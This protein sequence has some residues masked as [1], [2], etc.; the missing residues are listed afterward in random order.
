MTFDTY[1]KRT[2][3]F[4]LCLIIFLTPV[5][6][7]LLINFFGKDITAETNRY[8]GPACILGLAIF[9]YLRNSF[10]KMYIKDGELSFLEQ[11][12]NTS[13]G[14]LH[15]REISKLFVLANDYRRNQKGTSDGSG[16][17]VEVHLQSGKTYVYRFVIKSGKDR[18]KLKQI[19]ARYHANGV[20]VTANGF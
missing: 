17:R 9:L 19:L 4:Y 1:T 14:Q 8:I 2:I 15:L 3:A 12:I 13:Y 20:V 6:A 18:D 16:N 7:L 10:V 11:T 5:T